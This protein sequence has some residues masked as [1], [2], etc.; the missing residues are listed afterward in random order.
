MMYS[1]LVVITERKSR[2]EEILKIRKSEVSVFELKTLKLAALML[3]L[4]KQKVKLG[5]FSGV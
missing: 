5:I 4:Q 1:Q 3:D 2:R